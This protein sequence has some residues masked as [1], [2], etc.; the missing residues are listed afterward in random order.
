M[1][2]PI[3]PS[4][5]PSLDPGKSLV[6]LRG[7]KIYFPVRSGIRHNVTGHVHAV[8]DV[9]LDIRS[10]ETLGVVGESGSGKSTIG[11]GVLGLV[12]ATAGTVQFD[13]RDIADLPREEMRSLRRHMQMVFQDPYSAFDPMA[14]LGHSVAEPLST[15]FGLSVDDSREQITQLMAR[16]SL[17][18]EFL[19]RYPRELS[20]GQLQRLSIVRALTLRPQ[21]IVLDEPVSALDVS[22]QAQVINLLEELRYEFHLT[23]LLIAHNPGLVH[24]ASDR[25][26]VMYLGRIVER[27]GADDVFRRPKHPYTYSLLSAIPV[28]NP[29]VRP[30]RIVL[31]GDIPSPINPPDGCRFHPRCPWAMDICRTV[32]PEAY[33]SPDGSIVHCHLHTSGPTLAGRSV[34]DLPIPSPVA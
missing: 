8:D 22:T 5:S 28:A 26:A 34:R 4:P 18:E 12:R 21:L 25:I 2:S 7:L 30:Q 24:H 27:G 10:G 17:P 11:R 16:V 23:Y 20:G 32:D 15:H 3:A 14:R 1:T 29:L 13:G 19:D 33:R 6:E 9:D 31:A